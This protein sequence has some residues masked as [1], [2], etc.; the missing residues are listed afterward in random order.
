MPGHSTVHHLIEVVHQTCLAL[1]NHKIN[2]QVFLYISKAFEKVWHR[3]LI[4]KLEKYGITGN[5]LAW[6]EN[7]LYM[8]HQKVSINNTCSSYKFITA[9]VPQGSVLGPMLFSIYINDISETLTGIGQLFA[10][11]TSLSFSSADPV[12]IERILNQ[13]VI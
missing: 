5:L 13:G 8:R 7:Y 10:D 1:E 2:C 12:E 4:L 9:G 11:D 6:F 3:G